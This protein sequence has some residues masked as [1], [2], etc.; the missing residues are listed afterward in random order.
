[1]Q[2]VDEENQL[3]G[4][5]LHLGEDGLQPLLELTAVLRAG[6]H[7]PDVERPDALALQSLGHVAR[8]DPLREPLDD[9]SLADAGVA[10]QHRVVLRAPREHLDHAADLLVAADDRVQLS[11]LGELGEIAAELLERLVGALGILRGDAL[12]APH[13]RDLL[14]ERVSRNDVQGKQKVLGR[15]VIV[16][17]LLRLVGGAVEHARERG[18]DLR[19]LLGPLR[20]RLGAQ[21]RLGLGAQLARVGHELLRQLLV[22]EREQQMLGVELGVAESPPELLGRGDRIL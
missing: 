19:L 15:D 6:E 21:R 17:E 14:E 12:A 7:R 5:V 9:R 11:L 2:L 4:G 1:V 20:G 13:V 22:E 18:R 10:D 16:L 3:A 8:H